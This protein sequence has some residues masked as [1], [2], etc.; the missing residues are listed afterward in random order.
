[1]NVRWDA[2]MSRAEMVDEGVR[3][4]YTDKDNALRASMLADPAGKRGQHQRQ[5]AGGGRTW[6]WCPA[7]R[8]R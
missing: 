1:M 3:R 6:S 7:R 4:A 5:H 8:S 2:K